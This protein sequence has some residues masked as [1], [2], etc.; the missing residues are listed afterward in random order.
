MERLRLVE[1][2]LQ[3]A[4]MIGKRGQIPDQL[5]QTAVRLY[6]DAKTAKQPVP[7]SRIAEQLLRF[8]VVE[9]STVARDAEAVAQNSTVEERP[10]PWP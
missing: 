2:A 5:T 6:K 1:R 7:F 10:I 4:G 8:G 3:I 9:P